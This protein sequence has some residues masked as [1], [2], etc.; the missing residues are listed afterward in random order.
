MI[1]A[2]STTTCIANH[3]LP[4]VLVILPCAPHSA[5]NT[6]WVWTCL[7][8]TEIIECLTVTLTR[9]IVPIKPLCFPVPITGN[10]V[11]VLY[12]ASRAKEANSVVMTVA[13]ALIT[14]SA[15]K[16]HTRLTSDCLSCINV[17]HYS[18]NNYTI[19]HA[20]GIAVY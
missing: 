11:S 1:P 2:H 6:N 14:I 3:V 4:D 18:H 12:G 7:G 15:D 19:M 10:A 5:F 20:R 8:R 9:W 16:T 13:I 17:S